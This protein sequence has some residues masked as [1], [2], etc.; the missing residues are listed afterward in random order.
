MEGAALLPSLLSSQAAS[1]GPWLLPPAQHNGWHQGLA[2]EETT[3]VG[4]WLA[5]S[6]KEGLPS[7][8]PRVSLAL[9]SPV[10]TYG[11]ETHSAKYNDV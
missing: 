7:Y 4:K 1:W 2:G 6:G 9:L 8:C 3:Q 10:P 11:S 5:A